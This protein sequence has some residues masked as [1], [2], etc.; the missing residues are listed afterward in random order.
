VRARCAPDVHER[1]DGTVRTNV[2]AAFIVVRTT[3]YQLNTLYLAVSAKIL[4]DLLFG[5]GVG[6]VCDQQISRFSN[7]VVC[8]LSNAVAALSPE[9]II[10]VRRRKAATWRR[11]EKY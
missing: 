8:R 1:D 2:A 9:L 11:E 6:Q 3:P 7:H 5:Y 10:H 4:S